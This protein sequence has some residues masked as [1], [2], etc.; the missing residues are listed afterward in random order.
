MFRTEAF[1]QTQFQDLIA[2]LKKVGHD[3]QQKLPT[4]W[5]SRVFLLALHMTTRMPTFSTWPPNSFLSFHLVQYI[6]RIHLGASEP[7]LGHFNIWMNDTPQVRQSQF[8]QNH[9]DEYQG[10]STLPHTEHH[11]I[12]PANSAQ[13]PQPSATATIDSFFNRGLIAY[14]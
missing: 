5:I 14:A 13:P 10:T 9:F 12:F 11:I 4:T 3:N 6:D 8:E 7:P 2:T 1:G